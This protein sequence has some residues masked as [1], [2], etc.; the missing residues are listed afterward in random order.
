MATAVRRKEVMPSGTRPAILHAG[1]LRSK[2]SRLLSS[3][4]AGVASAQKHAK[5]LW[6][7]RKEIGLGGDY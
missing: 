1:M 2:A 4:M 5:R 6:L 7:N 3:D